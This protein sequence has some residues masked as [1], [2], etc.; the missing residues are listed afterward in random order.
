MI[1]PDIRY[2]HSP[3]AED[4]AAYRPPDPAIF[5][6]LIQ[7]VVGPAGKE[8][9]ESFDVQVVSPGWLLQRYGEKEIISGEFRLLVFNYDWFLIEGYLRKRVSAC[10]GETWDD[11]AEKIGRF[12]R[13]EFFDYQA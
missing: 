6:L 4:L 11:V 9:E 12:A 8:G 13:W 1:R 10:V 7:I 5:A 2:F 3:D